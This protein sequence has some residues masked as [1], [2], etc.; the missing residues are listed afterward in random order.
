MSN[1]PRNAATGMTL[2]QMRQAIKD[3]EALHAR[4]EAGELTEVDDLPDEITVVEAAPTPDNLVELNPNRV[5]NAQS[6][7]NPGGVPVVDGRLE[8]TEP[9][10]ESEPE[11][12]AQPKIPKYLTAR[13]IINAVDLP[14]ED[15]YVPE[16]GGTVR[17]QGLTAGAFER[18][19]VWAMTTVTDEDGNE[20]IVQKPETDIYMARARLVALCM[21][22]P[23]TQERVFSDEDVEKLNRKAVS[24]LSKLYALAGQLCV[25]SVKARAAL[26]KG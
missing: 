13:D 4:V 15:V 16:W 2:T 11:P 25:T 1:E 14:C 3:A 22:H 24:V 18:W 17:M 21:V 8:P 5:D 23:E 20:V 19:Q 9:E 10:L 7:D 12:P 6:F 26:G